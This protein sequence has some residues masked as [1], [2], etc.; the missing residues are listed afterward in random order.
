[1]INFIQSIIKVS[2][3]VHWVKNFALFAALIF[4]G[5]LFVRPYFITVFWAFIAFNLITSA[6]YIFNDIIDAKLDRLHPT[7]KF[8]PIASGRLPVQVA[9]LLMI[10]LSGSA[11]YLSSLLHPLFFLS[12]LSYFVLQILYSLFL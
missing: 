4:T 11:L 10:V 1:M 7:K 6:T 3:P 8:R 5:T 9:F 2:R 12:V